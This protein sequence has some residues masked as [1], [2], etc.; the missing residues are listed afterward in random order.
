MFLQNSAILDLCSNYTWPLLAM[1]LG[2][3]LLG[4]IFWYAW[5]LSKKNQFQAHINGLRNELGTQQSKIS[6][7][8]TDIRN[9]NYERVQLEQD[10][11]ILKGKNRDLSLLYNAKQQEHEKLKVNLEDDNTIEFEKETND[12]YEEHEEQ[13]IGEQESD[14]PLSDSSFIEEIEQEDEPTDFDDSAMTDEEPI[15]SNAESDTATTGGEAK[16]V[17]G[18][19]KKP[20]P[21][22]GYSKLK[23]DNLK[24]IEGI[25]PK[26]EQLLKE[27][28]INSWEELAETNT[29]T[30]QAILNEKGSRYKIHNPRNWSH[31]AKLAAL[32]KWDELIQF[33]KALQGPRIEQGAKEGH[34]KVEKV[35]IK[36]LGFT[37]KSDDLKI[38]EGIGPKIESVL[39]AAGIENWS[40][41]AAINAQEIKAILDQAGKRFRLH[42]PTTWPQ[43][44][45]LAVEAKWDELKK[46]QDK[47]DGGKA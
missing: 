37:Q 23:L 30:L 10:N 46:L 34:A 16:D 32:N 44:A 6:A 33:Q 25:G 15:Y 35:M 5:W 11:K 31:Q 4:L 39:K 28:G 45:R 22:F 47:L 20:T 40:K 36:L 43:Q 18:K 17:N 21:F 3:W 42:D 14:V 41:L 38:V 27:K 9:I 29:A 7:L 26:L 8:E 24:I 12:I 1:L 13:N 19:H 2:A